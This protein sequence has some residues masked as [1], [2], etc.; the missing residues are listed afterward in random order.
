MVVFGRHGAFVELL[1]DLCQEESQASLSAGGAGGVDGEPDILGGLLVFLLREGG[2]DEGCVELVALR[3]GEVATGEV[4]GQLVESRFGFGVAFLAYETAC[5]E[6]GPFVA[7]AC[8]LE[9]GDED[10]GGVGGGDEVLFVECGVGREEVALFDVG[11]MFLAFEEDA[12]FLDAFDA[13][14]DGAVHLGVDGAGCLLGAEILWGYEACIV[15]DGGFVEL[16]AAGLE[17][18]VAVPPD[19]VVTGDVVVLDVWPG[20]LL[21]GTGDQERQCSDG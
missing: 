3:A 18:L 6:Y 9:L 12:V 17:A 19:V 1:V 5:E 10:V 20:G 11:Y 15:V 16:L 14:L 7:G 21:S 8:A 2:L 13:F 4:V